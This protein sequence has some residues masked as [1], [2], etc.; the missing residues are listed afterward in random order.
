MIMGPGCPV[1]ITDVPEVDEGVALARPGRA[2]R[3]LWRHAA[4]PGHGAVAGGRPGRRRKGG[5]RL[6]RLPGGGA[7][8]QT[9]E[10][11]VFF[12]TGFETTAVATAASI[13]RRSTRK[14]LVLSAHKYIPPVMEIVARDAREPGGGIPRRGTRG[15]H[16]RLGG[17][18]AVRGAAPACRWS[19]LGS[20]HWTSWPAWS[21][22]CELIREGTPRGG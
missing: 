8:A 15:H 18:R 20:S 4:G 12:A 7:C 19:W 10:E 3:H 1:C 22:W 21:S 17:V 9:D 5:R 13:L 14:L 16:H 11:V 6:R 2:G